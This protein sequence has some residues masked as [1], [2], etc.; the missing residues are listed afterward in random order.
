M[1]K[2]KTGSYR[3]ELSKT[4]YIGEKL[5]HLRGAGVVHPHGAVHE[6]HPIGFARCDDHIKL[7]NIKSNWLLKQNVLLLAGG[8]HGPAHVQ[9][10]G[11]RQVDHVNLG[12]VEDGLVGAVHLGAGGEA[13]SAGEGASLVEGAAPDGVQDGIG[14]ERDGAGDPAGNIGAADEAETDFGGFRH[15]ESCL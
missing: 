13:V 4:V 9:A 14:R 12:V 15:L 7:S 8:E 1:V 5:L 11:E 10:G 2:F 6:L 3:F